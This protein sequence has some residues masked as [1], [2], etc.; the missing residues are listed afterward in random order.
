MVI[1]RSVHGFF[2]GKK[3][4]DSLQKVHVSSYERRTYTAGYRGRWETLP[5]ALLTA[6]HLLWFVLAAFRCDWAFW[7]IMLWCVSDEV[8]VSSPSVKNR[9]RVQDTKSKPDTT[10]YLLITS[11]AI[12]FAF[13]SLI[14]RWQVLLILWH[15]SLGIDSFGHKTLKR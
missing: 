12:H 11:A 5:R 14:T 8:Q 4:E 3:K 6:S 10:A 13:I 9:G 7:I 1:A 15:P 2:L